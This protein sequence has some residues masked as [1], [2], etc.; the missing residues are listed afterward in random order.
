MEDRTNVKYWAF[1][2][3]ASKF[4]KRFRLSEMLKHCSEVTKKTEKLLPDF[5]KVIYQKVSI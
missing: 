3:C 2:D 4:W 5:E 1:T